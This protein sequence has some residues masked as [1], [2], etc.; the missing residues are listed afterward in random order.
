M[1]STWSVRSVSENV[2]PR[3]DGHLTS[4]HLIAASVRPPSPRFISTDWRL[5]GLEYFWQ[6][7]RFAQPFVKEWPANFWQAQFCFAQCHSSVTHTALLP[8]R[9]KRLWQ[10]VGS[11]FMLFRVKTLR[12]ASAE[13]CRVEIL[14]DWKC[15]STGDKLCNCCLCFSRASHNPVGH[16]SWCCL[17]LCWELE[18]L[19]CPNAFDA[20]S[21]NA[22]LLVV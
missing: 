9:G 13:Q 12:L 3:L 8:L 22:L 4:E 1:S 14:P 18:V 11:H 6:M 5:S 10:R 16:L 7:E 21:Q 15:L 20:H 2:F 19:A 17:L